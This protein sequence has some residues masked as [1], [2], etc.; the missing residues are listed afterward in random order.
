MHYNYAFF[1]TFL[2]NIIYLCRN[3]FDMKKKVVL[4]LL[5]IVFAISALVVAFCGVFY[6][7]INLPAFNI[8][9]P[10]YI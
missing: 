1:F 7:K 8:E 6:S 4:I 5:I 9:K 10:S 3:F 2:K